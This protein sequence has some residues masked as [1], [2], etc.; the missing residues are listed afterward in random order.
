MIMSIILITF[1]ISS[2]ILSFLVTFGVLRLAEKKKVLAKLFRPRDIH[3]KPVPL[4]GGLAIYISLA[5]M[6][7]LAYFIVDFEDK[8][9]IP[10]H[11][12]LGVLVGGAVLIIFGMAD[13]KYNFKPHESIWGPILAA[14]CAVVVGVRIGTVTNPLGGF[15]EFGGWLAIVISFI[16]L[17]GMMYT[18]KLLDGLDGL[19]SGIV[20]IGVLAIF[21]LS[22]TDVYWQPTMALYALIF[23]GILIGFLV[24]NWHPAKIFLGEGGST[25]VGFVLGVLAIISGAKVATALLVMGIP[26]LDVIWVIARRKFLEHHRVSIGDSKH[27]HFR[28]LKAGF[29]HKRAVLFYYFIAASFGAVSLFLQSRQKMVALALLALLMLVIGIIVTRR[30]GEIEPFD[31]LRPGKLRN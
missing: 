8:M 15:L 13:D 22:I 28:L 24:W 7:W 14:I 1:F 5:V 20:L 17:C 16:W 11:Y 29:S 2:I 31:K 30:N 4:W 27:L 9:A 12:L 19:A 25:L 3:K 18:T 26:I 10:V 6:I 23:A 21:F